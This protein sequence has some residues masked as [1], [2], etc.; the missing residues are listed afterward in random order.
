MVPFVITPSCVY[1]GD[2]GFFFTPMIDNWKV[3]FKS[4]IRSFQSAQSYYFTDYS[5]CVTFA[6]LNRN[7]IGRTNLSIFTG[8][9]VKPS[10]TKVA[11][12]TIRFQALLLLF[13]VRI[14]LNISSSAIPRTFGNGTAYFAALSLRF[15]LRAV[16][17]A[18]ASLCPSLSK[19]Y[20]GSAPSGVEA[21]SDCLTLR[22]S[23]ALRV[24]RS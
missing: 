22:S 18:F 11:F 14:T 24:L 20:V 17:S 1:I 16:L 4:A 23:C 8:L 5:R 15:C 3:A 19:R 21:A 6:R 13:P 10:P 2:C 9:R 7:A 12:V